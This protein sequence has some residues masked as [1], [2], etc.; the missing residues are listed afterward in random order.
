MSHPCSTLSKSVTALSCDMCGI[1]PASICH[2]NPQVV[3]QNRIKHSIKN[4]PTMPVQLKY[5]LA[6]VLHPKEHWNVPTSL[7][8]PHQVSIS[9]WLH[10]VALLLPQPVIPIPADGALES[11]IITNSLSTQSPAQ[12]PLWLILACVPAPKEAL[13]CCHSHVLPMPRSLR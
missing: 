2:S 5:I 13:V 10:W 7:S 6:S 11:D 9:C 1:A 8:H 4:H 12:E 3:T